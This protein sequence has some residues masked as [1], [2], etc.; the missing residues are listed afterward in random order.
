MY[1]HVLTGALVSAF[2]WE[3][4]SLLF[5]LSAVP[6]IHRLGVMGV[7]VGMYFALYHTD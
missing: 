3:C 5:R 6:I 7:W 1:I 2:V 4:L